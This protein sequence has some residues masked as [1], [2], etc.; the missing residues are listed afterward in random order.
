[1]VSVTD[2]MTPTAPAC[3]Q[4]SHSWRKAVFR[5]IGQSGSPGTEAPRNT[6]SQQPSQVYYIPA[7]DVGL[8]TGGFVPLQASDASSVLTDQ[9]D[10]YDACDVRTPLAQKWPCH[11]QAARLLPCAPS[12]VRTALVLEVWVTACLVLVRATLVHPVD[13]DPDPDP[14]LN[15]DRKPLAL[16]L[17][18]MPPAELLGAQHQPGRRR[19][20][21]PDI[22]FGVRLQ[23]EVLGR[24]GG[25]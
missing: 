12:E 10:D 24:D 23:Q 11:R 8:N 20:G 15:P 13:T 14:H 5:T 6:I 25:R 16:V 17:T 19:S 7:G 2:A 18:F 22:L 1:M 21:R 4:M 3:P 9:Y